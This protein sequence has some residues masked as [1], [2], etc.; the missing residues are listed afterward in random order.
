MAFNTL[1]PAGAV[2][3]ARIVRAIPGASEAA[4]VLEMEHHFHRD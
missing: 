1:L 3:S 2:K 4:F